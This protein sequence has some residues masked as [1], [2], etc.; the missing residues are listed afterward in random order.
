MYLLHSSS[1]NR[2]GGCGTGPLATV[3]GRVALPFV[4]K[5]VLPAAKTIG[6][7]LPA[8]SVR[9]VF[10][11]ITERKSPRKTAKR[12]ISK[13]IEKQIGGRGKQPRRSKKRK[14]FTKSKRK[15]RNGL[16]SF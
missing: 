7:E 5:F 13:T 8:Q 16:I 14:T 2:Q 11:F 10:G 4:E 15:Q 3:I 1:Y 6:E 9:G 12:G